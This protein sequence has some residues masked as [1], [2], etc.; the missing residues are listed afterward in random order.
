L[1]ANHHL[2]FADLALRMNGFGTEAT[3]VL[4]PF[5]RIVFDEA[6]HI[7]KS[8]T[9]YFSS[10]FNRMFLV[11]QLGRL[12]RKRKGRAGGLILTLQGL[13]TEQID[14]G[15]FPALIGSV[16][17]LHA[18]WSVEAL[19]VLEGQVSLRIAGEAGD[20]V[21]DLLLP[22][23][24]VLQH[25]LNQLSELCLQLSEAWDDEPE[26]PSESRE[27]RTIGRRLEGLSQLVDRC[28][29]FSRDQQNVY[30]LERVRDNL[31][32]AQVDLTISPLS[33][34]PL[35]VKAVFDPYESVMFT[36]ATLTVKG[37]FQFWFSRVGLD[38][39][40][41]DRKI[42]GV[43]PS[44]FDYASRVLLACPSDFPMP[45]HPEYQARLEAYLPP[46]L[47]AAKGSA[48]V[49]FTSYESM[50]N[51]WHKTQPALAAAGIAVYRQ[52][53]AER[54][55]L[56][57]RFKTEISSVLFAT[58][59]FW[60]GVD[61]PGDTLRLVVL[62]RL[63]FRVPSEPV[64]AARMELLQSQGL[65]PFLNFSLPEAVTKFKQGFGRL[66]RHTED[67]GCVVVLDTRLLRKSYG[68][69]FL[70]SIPETA[71]SW[72]TSAELLDSL[73]VFLAST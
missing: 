36:S 21:M 44:P 67:S 38:L 72:E 32:S 18:A 3:A 50:R 64:L 29:S 40:D 65:D 62:C 54:T 31:G 35:M 8:A 63:P 73:P 23:L 1:V 47:M 39:V 7:E 68:Q 16:L 45:E 12:Y 11:K 43:F 53:E 61:S 48:L 42:S 41:R 60:E 27:V 49:L 20:R 9:S 4:P 69:V 34:S 22:G 17:D 70:A 51:A 59:S 55:A 6:H 14:F 52:G 46:L 26:I 13:G 5:Q 30:W 2:L 15:R 25:P 28:K 57:E 56:L 71:R 10:T 24:Q 37:D 58:D 33:I 19:A 66:M